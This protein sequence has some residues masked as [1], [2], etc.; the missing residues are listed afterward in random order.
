LPALAVKAGSIIFGFLLL[1]LWFL[2]VSCNFVNKSIYT[3]VSKK[4]YTHT[5]FSQKYAHIFYSKNSMN[6]YSR[7]FYLH[8]WMYEHILT[9]AVLF[10]YVY[11]QAKFGRMYAY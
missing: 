9:P 10:K 1:M 4:V 8:T 11:I 6:T 3:N 5:P 2:H 7:F